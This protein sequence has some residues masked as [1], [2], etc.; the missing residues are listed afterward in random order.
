VDSNA[1]VLALLDNLIEDVG[2]LRV[3]VARLEE[4]VATMAPKPGLIRDG[5]ITISGGAVGA[6]V[7]AL[8]QHFAAK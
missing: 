3:A 2:D 7:L 8:V 6:A 4:R 1:R 5:G